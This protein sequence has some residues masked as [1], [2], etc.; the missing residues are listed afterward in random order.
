[1]GRD[2]TRDDKA[3]TAVERTVSKKLKRVLGCWRRITI[4]AMGQMRIFG[5]N[6]INTNAFSA[7]KQTTSGHRRHQKPKAI[8]APYPAAAME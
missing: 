2:T 1:M 6:P 7:I 5:T 8:K 3:I 4:V